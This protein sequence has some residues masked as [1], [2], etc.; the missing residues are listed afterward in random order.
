MLAQARGRDRRDD[1]ACYPDDPKVPN[2]SY[3]FA[4]ALSELLPRILPEIFSRRRPRPGN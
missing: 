2:L 4:D 3:T 1:H